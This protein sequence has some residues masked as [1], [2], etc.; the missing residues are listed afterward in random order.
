MAAFPKTTAAFRSSVFR[1]AMGGSRTQAKSLS[2]RLSETEE[3]GERG[4]FS[5]VTFTNKT[6]SELADSEFSGKAK[7]CQSPRTP[8]HGG[9]SSASCETPRTPGGSFRSAKLGG[10]KTPRTPGGR[11]IRRS[12]SDRTKIHIS[13][14]A[15]ATT[16]IL[17][18][19]GPTAPG[20]ATPATAAPEQDATILKPNLSRAEALGARPGHFDRTHAKRVSAAGRIE[21]VVPN[22]AGAGDGEEDGDKS[23]SPRSSKTVRVRRVLKPG[24]NTRSPKSEVRTHFVTDANA[25][26]VPAAKTDREKQLEDRLAALEA[27]LNAVNEASSQRQHHEQN[28]DA[29]AQ[30]SVPALVALVS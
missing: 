3:L 15:E 20:T 28:L 9:R 24:G 10:E 27:Q 23:P 16:V 6:L 14:S 30:Q 4:S 22:D 11:F 13:T 19:N 7:N 1:R 21:I 5:R 2:E 12:T 26:V 18:T 17:D 8:G 29:F 25:D